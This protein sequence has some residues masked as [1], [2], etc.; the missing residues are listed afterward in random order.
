LYNSGISGGGFALVRL[1]NNTYEMVDF[2]EK[3]PG[4]SS[5]TMFV[6][7][8]NGSQVGGRAMY[9]VN[10]PLNSVECH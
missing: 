3:A 1:P 9:V 7:D 4:S 5:E 6:N 8:K 10:N 2:R